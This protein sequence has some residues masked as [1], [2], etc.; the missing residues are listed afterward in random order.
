MHIVCVNL[1]LSC[2]THTLYLKGTERLFSKSD[3]QLI[4]S[5]SAFLKF[6]VYIVFVFL[7]KY[8]VHSVTLT[9][10][11]VVSF[12]RA[13]RRTCS[14][15]RLSSRGSCCISSFLWKNQQEF[16]ADL[17][18]LQLMEATLDG[19]IRSC[20]QQLFD[21]TDNMENAAYPF[22]SLLRPSSR[23]SGACY[24]CRNLMLLLK[25]K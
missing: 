11:T 1:K 24:C 8:V 6:L 20:S 15:C 13:S 9:L 19:L 22:T 14:D 7:L 10:K 17:D 25:P 3:N 2:S 21:I 16:Q 18:N 23:H 4:D 5:F 12:F